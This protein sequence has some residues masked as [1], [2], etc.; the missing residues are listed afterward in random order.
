MNSSYDAAK[1]FLNIPAPVIP[2][3]QLS[4]FDFLD[5]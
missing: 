2:A 3:G 5:E 1:Q 4:I